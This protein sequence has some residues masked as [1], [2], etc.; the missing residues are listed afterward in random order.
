MEEKYKRSKIYTI[1]CRYDDSL[2]YV[3]ST[4]DSL[5]KRFGA[6]KDKSKRASYPLYK[7]IDNNWDNWYIELYEQFPCNNK[8]E[9]RKREGEVIREIGNLNKQIASRTK[10][11]Y[12]QDNKES[13]YEW[14]KVW[15]ENNKEKKNEY[16]KKYSDNNRERIKEKAKEKIK[17][18]KC[19][20]E[21]RRDSLA[22]H[23]KSLKCINYNVANN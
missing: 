4:I 8:D 14:C 6:H 7:K 16:S 2:I 22:K 20:A 13:H 17:C 15:N 3:G 10:K 12:Y 5:A 21:I 11:D 18:E 9:L 19:G 1:R 23:V